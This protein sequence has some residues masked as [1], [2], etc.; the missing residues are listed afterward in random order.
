ME[1]RE[2]GEQQCNGSCVSRKTAEVTEFVQLHPEDM[3]DDVK[4]E[5]AHRI[6]VTLFSPPSASGV[7]PVARVTAAP[8]QIMANGS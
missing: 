6:T 1:G 7:L 8:G 4:S 3:A 5:A 2:P